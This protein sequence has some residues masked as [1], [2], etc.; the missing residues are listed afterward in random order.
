MTPELNHSSSSATKREQKSHNDYTVGWICAL[1]KELAA[2]RAMLE[3]EHLP[4]SKPSNDANTYALGSIGEHNI[5]I[6]CLP[7]G[8]TGTNQAAI[9]ATRMVSTFQAI[10]VGLMVGIGGGIPPK[11][12]LGDV[13]VSKPA[14]Q[15]PGVVQWDFGKAEKGGKFRRTGALNKPPTAL[16]T[17]L[18]SL[19]SEH[20]L[21]GTR[22][23]TYLDEAG[24]RFPSFGG[25]YKRPEPHGDPLSTPHNSQRDQDA[26]G[27]GLFILWAAVLS[28]LKYIFGTWAFGPI[29]HRIEERVAS[30]DAQKTQK[31]AE[32]V[33]IHYGL[34]ASGNQVIK[35]RMLRDRLNESLGGDVLCVEMEA[36]GLMDDFPCIVIR[37]ICDYADSNK[38]DEWQEYAAAIAA[39]YAKDFLGCL[40]PVAISQEPPVKDI[41]LNQVHEKV[42]KVTSRLE[43]EDDLKILEWLTPI[44]YGPRHNDIAQRRQPGTGQWLL[45]STEYHNWLQNRKQILFCPGIPGA[46]KTFL[47]S[48]VV[49]HLCRFF[50]NTSA[51]GIA[52]VYFNFKH[53]NEQT[54]YN[55]LASLL[56][57]LAQRQYSLPASIKDLYDQH[58]NNRTWPSTN[59]ITKALQAITKLYSST[60]IVVDALDECQISDYCRNNFLSTIFRLYTQCG[61]NIFATSRHIQEII[62]QFKHQG[63]TTLEIRAHEEDLRS[64]LDGRIEQSTRK[65]LRDNREAIKAGI[66]KV[67][68]GMFLLARLHFESIETKTTPTKL[69][70]ALKRL[71]MGQGE[72]TYTLAYD[73]AMQRIDAQN[74]DFKRLAYRVLSWVVCAERPLAQLELQHALSVELEVEQRDLDE[75]N[76]PEVTDMI[77]VCAGLVTIDEESNIVRLIHYTTQEYFNQSQEQWIRD[78]QNDI[79]KAC[80]TYLSFETFDTELVPA[81]CEFYYYAAENWGHHARKSSLG[82]TELIISDFLKNDKRLSLCSRAI[83]DIFEPYDNFRTLRLTGMTG[84][85]IAAYF[86]LREYIT[87]LL[88][89]GAN[90]ES[91]DK[92]GRTPLLWAAE[93]GHIDV[94]KLLLCE[95]AD[96][97]ARDGKWRQTPLSWAAERG[98]IDIVRLLLCEGAD[99]EGKDGER[100]QTPL[101][102]ATIG[103]NVGAVR[104][105]LHE[106]ADIEAKDSIFSRRPLS[107]ATELGYANIVEL[108]LHEGADRYIKDRGG[109][110]PLMCATMKG[111]AEIVGL[112]L[113]K[114]PNIDAQDEGFRAALSLARRSGQVDIVEMLSRA[115]ANGDVEDKSG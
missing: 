70:E 100:G 14:D 81:S 96:L 69:K 7:D 113:H 6:A 46:G 26:R 66:V 74:L 68:D 79:A 43:K 71:A 41:I 92:E 57:Q 36:A 3:H 97:E 32:D 27:A 60:F 19:R 11:V 45:G 64:Y 98:N 29:H 50:S 91:E 52:Y 86:G 55:I 75:G 77:S 25:K 51:V 87:Q 62:E 83:N 35:D 42:T 8:M 99:L 94:V 107:W 33:G 30:I 65:M 21:H 112:L 37:G 13:V 31:N 53:K 20:D 47:T 93:R 101:V 95:G 22:F 63:S 82:P 67:V 104:L 1:P 40:Q 61:I 72:A 111:Y 84:M 110:S 23:Q 44:E 76:F 12:R 89:E 5:V 9:I 109:R 102:W 56:K 48:I 80:V 10:K 105:L 28:L 106:G 115:G 24:E 78:A 39:A 15:C 34:I 103:G 114:G 73:E 17:A 16:L 88:R 18:S 90:P 2:A 38:N 59:E 85:H 49:D 54:I 108:L 4:L 58:K